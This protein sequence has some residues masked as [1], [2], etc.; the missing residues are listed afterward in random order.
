MIESALV[1]MD[2]RRRVGRDYTS[3]VSFIASHF[4]EISKS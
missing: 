3:A 4:E 2:V 1:Q